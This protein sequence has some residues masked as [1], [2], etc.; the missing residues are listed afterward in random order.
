MCWGVSDDRFRGRAVSNY[1]HSTEAVMCVIPGEVVGRGSRVRCANACV[2]NKHTGWDVARGGVGHPRACSRQALG[3]M[4]THVG[5]SPGKSFFG[6]NDA[7]IIGGKGKQLCWSIKNYLP[8]S[9]RTERSVKSSTQQTEGTRKPLAPEREVLF[10]FLLLGQSRSREGVSGET[11][12]GW[13][14]KLKCRTTHMRVCRKSNCPVQQAWA[15]CVSHVRQ[16]AIER[17]EGNPKSTFVGVAVIPQ[18][19]RHWSAARPASS[20]LEATA[21]TEHCQIFSC[22]ILSSQSNLSKVPQSYLTSKC[23]IS[24]PPPL[25]KL[26]PGCLSQINNRNR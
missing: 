21:A 25:L 15:S 19:T 10:L 7:F 14:S 12:S 18:V 8:S 26:L 22:L 20:C 3:A 2:P 17:D 9:P 1:V 24:K 16:A 13:G 4:G 11:G 23:N 6:H 5:R